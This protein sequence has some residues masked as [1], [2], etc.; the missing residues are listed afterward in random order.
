MARDIHEAAMRLM[1]V[2]RGDL[3]SLCHHDPSMVHD[4]AAAYV[5]GEGPV[6]LILFC[7]RCDERHVDR[8]EHP[9][10]RTHACQGCGFLWAPSNVETVGVQFLK[11]CKDDGGEARVIPDMPLDSGKMYFEIAVPPS[12]VPCQYC[13]HGAACDHAGGCLDSMP[14]CVDQ[15]PGLAPH[16]ARARSAGHRNAY[17]PWSTDDDKCLRILASH[18]VP[19]EVL[20][21]VFGRTLGGIGSRIEHLGLGYLYDGR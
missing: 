8:P 5:A 15:K 17:E 16:V 14:P 18:K 10:H 2:D 12:F 11:G 3:W 20:S 21:R 6:E 9:P 19:Q 13:Q 7:P 1:Q 4:V